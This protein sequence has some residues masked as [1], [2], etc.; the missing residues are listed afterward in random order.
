MICKSMDKKYLKK[1]KMINYF[2]KIKA[3]FKT[4]KVILRYSKFS[5]KEAKKFKN[6]EDLNNL[7]N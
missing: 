6:K 7:M 4:I 5:T 3:I 1:I 2:K